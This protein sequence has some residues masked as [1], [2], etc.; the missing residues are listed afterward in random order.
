[1]SAA[2]LLHSLI[3]NHAFY[4][5]NKRTALVSTLVMLEKNGF[6]MT[7]DEDEIFRLLLLIAQHKLIPIHTNEMADREMLAIAEWLCRCS[8]EIDKSERP[9]SGRRLK[10]ILS[11]YNCKL[12]RVPGGSK[13]NISRELVEKHMLGIKRKK[14]LMTQ[15]HFA[16]DGKDIKKNAIS[17]VRK[18]LNLDE[19][20]GIDSHV[21][22]D[23]GQGEIADFIIKYSKILKKLAKF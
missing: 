11:T 20:N 10:Q 21:F 12:E 7:C 18:D 6:M 5:G 8:R 19:N 3:Q 2:A 22:Y 1:M 4:N 17:K 9:I 15:I 14:V 13:M 23:Q 16:D